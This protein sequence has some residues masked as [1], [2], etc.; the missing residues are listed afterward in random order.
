MQYLRA[1]DILMLLSAALFSVIVSGFLCAVPRAFLG[2]PFS[3]LK[4]KVLHQPLTW[5]SCFHY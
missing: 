5:A 3:H 4:L 2:S 1:G